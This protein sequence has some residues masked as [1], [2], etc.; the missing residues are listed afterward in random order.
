VTAP[1]HPSTRRP[2]TRRGKAF[3]LALNRLLKL[4]QATSD[5]TVTRG[6]RVPMRDGVELLGDH[7]APTSPAKG[8]LLVR[9]PYGRSGLYATNYARLYAV[10][11]NTRMPSAQ[12]RPSRHPVGGTSTNE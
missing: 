8:T 11:L 12:G 4:P 7:Y 10:L 9:G 6:V 3:D 1:Q 2:R 5:Y